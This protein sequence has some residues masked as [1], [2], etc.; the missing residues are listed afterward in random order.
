MQIAVDD[1]EFVRLTYPFRQEL[2]AHCYRMMGSFQD[3]E[4]LVQETYVRAWRSFHDFE[5]RSSTRLWALPDS[6]QRVPD[7]TRSSQPSFAAIGSG[8]AERR[9][10]SSVVGAGGRHLASTA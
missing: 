9:P 4:D 5:G 6:D 7:R 2:L 1:D 8:A 3:A 10:R